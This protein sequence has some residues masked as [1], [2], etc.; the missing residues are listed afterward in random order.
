VPYPRGSIEL[1]LSYGTAPEPKR[2]T[3]ELK[4]LQSSNIHVAYIN[5]NIKPEQEKDFTILCPAFNTIAGFDVGSD[6]PKNYKDVIRIKINGGNLWNKN[7]TLWKEREMEDCSTI[8]YATWK[9][10]S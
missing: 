1:S 4:G 9:E 8:F 6:T 3:P 2:M 7:S 5:R 10:P